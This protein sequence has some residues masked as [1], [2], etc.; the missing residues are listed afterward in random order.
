[1]KNVT[2]AL[3]CCATFLSACDDST[4]GAAKN[5]TGEAVSEKEVLTKPV[6][7]TGNAPVTEVKETVIAAADN[8]SEDNQGES[9]YKSKCV[10]C[11][12]AGIAGAPKL[13]DKAA[14]AARIAQGDDVLVQHAIKGFKG[15]TGYMP[16][17]GGSMSLSDEVIA[18]TV[19]YVVSQSQ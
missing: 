6:P 8:A 1:M 14:W 17:K 3:L 2:L 16:P 7:E 9:T 11:H 18:A 12:G 19:Q 15:D 13:G 4:T 10:A 5:T